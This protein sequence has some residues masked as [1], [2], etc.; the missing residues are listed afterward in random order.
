MG[1]WLSSSVDEP[2]ADDYRAEATLFAHRRNEF[3]TRSQEA[4]RSGKKAE[5][6]SLS[7]AAKAQAQLMAEA[8]KKAAEALFNKHNATRDVGELDLHGLFVKEAIEKV[9][10]RIALCKEMGRKDL[11]VIVGK[12]NHSRDG[13]AIL[14]PIVEKFIQK[15]SLSVTV[16]KPNDGCIYVEFDNPGLFQQLIDTCAVM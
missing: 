14:K 11:V 5:A 10:Q 12:G 13:N 7:N 2:S 3:L 4:W 6:K 8:N 1:N 16:G 9:E 15:Y